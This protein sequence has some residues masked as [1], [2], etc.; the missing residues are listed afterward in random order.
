MKTLWKVWDAYIGCI[1]QGTVSIELVHSFQRKKGRKIF[2]KEEGRTR[3]RC[4]LEVANRIVAWE[5]CGSNLGSAE[6]IFQDQEKKSRIF[7]PNGWLIYIYSR[8]PSGLAS[9][10]SQM[11]G[12]STSTVG[13]QVAWV[14]LKGKEVKRMEDLFCNNKKY[15]VSCNWDENELNKKKRAPLGGAN[16]KKKKKSE[17]LSSDEQSKGCWAGLWWIY[18]M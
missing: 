16:I 4:G 14:D 7:K 3:G 10:S 5:V 12:F 11:V 13:D 9:L 17:E 2:Y 18:I 8:R 6:T 15:T 1:N